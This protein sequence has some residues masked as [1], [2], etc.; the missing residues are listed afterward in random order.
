MPA[1]NVSAVIKALHKA[2]GRVVAVKIYRRGRM[3]DMERWQLA[4]EICLHSRMHHP[5]IVQLYAAWK[6][7]KHVY[8]VLQHCDGGW[9]GQ[10]AV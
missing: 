1:G 3:H 7:A 6:D 5:N 9:G 10:G 2:S 8:L 4:R